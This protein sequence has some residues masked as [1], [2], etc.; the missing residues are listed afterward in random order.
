MGNLLHS[1]GTSAIV[2][3]VVFAT[4]FLYY[5]LCFLKPQNEGAQHF[6]AKRYTEAAKSFRTVLKRRPP[7]S[8]EA[9]TRRRLADT[10]DVLGQTEEAS[11]EWARASAATSGG[12]R[13]PTA[14]LVQGDLF[15]RQQRYNEACDCYGRAL[16][17]LPTLSSPGRALIMAKLA[18]AHSEA[19]RSEET[20]RW[21]E[22]SLRNAPDKTIRLMMERMAGVGYSDTGDLE[23][24]E[25]HYRRCLLLS[26]EAGKPNEIA[27]SLATLGSVQHK[28]G[29]F[30][31]ALATSRQ[32]QNISADTA[33]LSI[34]V[35][36]ECLRDM[37]RFDEARAVMVRRRQGSNSDTSAL[38]RRVLAITNLGSA[39]VEISAECYDEALVYLEE[40]REGLKFVANSTIWPPPPSSGEY[41]A[42]LWCDASLANALAG[43]GRN[44]E[45]QELMASVETRLERFG[46]DRRTRLGTLGALG[47][48]AFCL[49]DFAASRHFWQECLA[50]LPDPVSLPMAYYW[51][52]EIALCQGETEMA[53]EAFR[54]SVAPKIDSLDAR[55]AQVRLDEMEGSR[56]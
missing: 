1:L 33:G 23:Q 53:R 51:L 44:R 50:C 24:A 18:L 11:A 17:L 14:L 54:K 30:E 55:R 13:D 43:T 5:W 36:T 34:V 31:E 20:I 4:S 32:A 27:H 37:G 3:A 8:I 6:Q 42:A 39:R 45:A 15:K 22:E 16:A 49:G 21:A 38:N 48:T 9:D 35:E 29:H 2:L 52:G 40:A 28:R 56:A 46:E 7:A 25:T 19:G 10:L 47:R 12:G 41:K 26:E